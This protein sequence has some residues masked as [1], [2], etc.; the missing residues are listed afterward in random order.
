VLRQ[1]VP[2]SAA[3]MLATAVGWAGAWAVGSTAALVIAASGGNMLFFVSMACGTPVIG[4]AQRHFLREWTSRADS[5]L[6]PSAIGWTALLAIEVF[7]PGLLSAISDRA[8]RLVETVSGYS[9][10][11]TVGA[12]VAGGL[13]LGAISGVAMAWLLESPGKTRMASLRT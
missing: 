11:S 1:R 5:W 12:S 2:R 6:V 13:L 4:L 10:S 8:S 7:V 9:P 3:W